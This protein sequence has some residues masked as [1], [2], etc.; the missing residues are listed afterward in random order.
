MVD[1]II[2]YERRPPRERAYYDKMSFAAYFQGNG[3]ASRAYMKTMEGIRDH[4]DG[5]GFDVERI[6]TSTTPNVVTRSNRPTT[7]AGI[8]FT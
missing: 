3:T 1:Q 5:L 2:A 4:L 8:R 7:T 6:Y